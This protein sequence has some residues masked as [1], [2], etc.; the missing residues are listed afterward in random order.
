MILTSARCKLSEQYQIEK[1]QLISNYCM[2]IDIFLDNLRK[3]IF[4][5]KNNNNNFTNNRNKKV[6]LRFEIA[7][8]LY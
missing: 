1:L 2:S 3:K 4:I 7:S 5:R 6:I 8:S